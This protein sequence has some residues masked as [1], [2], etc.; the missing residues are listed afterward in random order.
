M[1]GILGN[2]NGSGARSVSMPDPRSRMPA[3][4]VPGAPSVRMPDP[5]ERY[6][7]KFPIVYFDP[8]GNR[9]E[10]SKE[11][12]DAMHRRMSKAFSARKFPYTDERGRTWTEE[13]WY[14]DQSRLWKRAIEQAK[15]R[16]PTAP[17]YNRRLMGQG[18]WSVVNRP[19]IPQRYMR[20]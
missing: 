12:Y 20:R 17:E 5:R 10:M 15:E 13:E 3:G 16:G 7:T 6:P 8:A 1:A 19:N 4:W 9:H 11:E 14:E 2:W 18:N